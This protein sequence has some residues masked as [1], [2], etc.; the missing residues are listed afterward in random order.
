MEEA[1]LKKGCRTLRQRVVCP[2]LRVLAL[3]LCENRRTPPNLC[4]CARSNLKIVANCCFLAPKWTKEPPF[5]ICICEPGAAPEAS[6]PLF[7]PHARLLQAIRR[8]QGVHSDPV[9]R[10]PGD[11][12]LWRRDGCLSAQGKFVLDKDRPAPVVRRMPPQEAPPPILTTCRTATATASALSHI[13]IP[14]LPHR[15][16][17]AE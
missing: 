11:R 1:E 6:P 16:P 7:L 12:E 14:P 2:F 13:T 5:C 8:P 15:S 3:V 4:D 10:Q 9:R 17:P